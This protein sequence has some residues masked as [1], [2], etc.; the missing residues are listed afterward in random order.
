MES[1]SEFNLNEF[2]SRQE[3]GGTLDS[4]GEFTLDTEQAARKMAK[5]ALPEP[6][7]W[8]LKVVQ[9]AVAWEAAQVTVI[10]SRARTSFTFCPADPAL[11]PGPQGIVATLLSGSLD[12]SNPLAKL[13]IAMR[14]LVE[15]TALSF[16]LG[17]NNGSEEA[18]TI[19][20]GHDVSALPTEQRVKWGELS[21]PGIKLVVSHQCEGE[22]HYGRYAPEFALKEKRH[23][24]IREQLLRRAFV[25]PCPILLDGLAINLPL[26]NPYFGFTPELSPLR[27]VRIPP[28]KDC[29]ALP[30]AGVFQ[31]ATLSLW[32]G[33]KTASRQPEEPEEGFAWAVWQI[34]RPG[35]K[36]KPELGNRLLWVQE[37]VVVQIERLPVETDFSQLTLVVN[38]EG[39]S[40][41]L[42]GMTLIEQDE[43][44]IRKEYAIAR[45]SEGIRPVRHII[46]KLLRKNAKKFNKEERTLELMRQLKGASGI[47]A[48]SVPGLLLE[49]F[50]Q[51]AGFGL[52]LAGGGVAV[53]CV[54][55]L[56]RVVTDEQR[57][58]SLA[59]KLLIDA[60]ELCDMGIESEVE[61]Q[62]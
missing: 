55:A 59:D 17:V 12:A 46:P 28:K 9:A 7:S 39:L 29:P 20:A 61:E 45:A 15:Q 38:A 6:Y 52:V 34:L 53:K 2:L 16:V 23:L 62:A 14:A 1:S 57:L 49:L 33:P 40:T 56:L 54:S 13:C 8:V 44:E 51:P 48:A 35:A 58:A 11:V 60:R 30:T 24:K 4:E 25:C 22:F 5:F 18:E 26:L 37:G 31:E 19:Y 21:E 41:D 27:V 47:A 10:Q 43:R 50:I 36:R 42:T 32:S 3:V